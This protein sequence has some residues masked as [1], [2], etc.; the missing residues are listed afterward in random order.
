MRVPIAAVIAVCAWPV[1]VSA[2][3][4]AEPRSLLQLPPP[5]VEVTASV[6]QK[7][8]VARSRLSAQRDAVVATE[9]RAAECRDRF[10]QEDVA[11]EAGLT[12]LDAYRRCIAGREG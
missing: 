12:R 5:I 3:D 6:R 2:Q 4:A 7:L 11:V 8:E 9:V 1:T 10:Q